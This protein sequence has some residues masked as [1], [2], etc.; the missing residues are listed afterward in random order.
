MVCSNKK[1][2]YV[3]KVINQKLKLFMLCSTLIKQKAKHN[4][5]L[6]AN[7]NILK[8]TASFWRP[9]GSCWSR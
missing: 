9:G 2:Y 3:S 8:T 4:F 1:N 6:K 7:R 5:I